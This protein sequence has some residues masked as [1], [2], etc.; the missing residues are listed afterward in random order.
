MLRSTNN[1]FP[2]R[3]F[4]SAEHEL[5]YTFYRQGHVVTVDL[6][7]PIKY[8]LSAKI[9]DLDLGEM[10][11]VFDRALVVRSS[12]AILCFKPDEETGRWVQYHKI[13]KMRGSIF[14]I[15]RNVRI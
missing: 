15:K 5:C 8:M 4:Y 7:N 2:L 9:T 12:N 6:K 11:L 10:F 14:F 3:S 1:N 13:P